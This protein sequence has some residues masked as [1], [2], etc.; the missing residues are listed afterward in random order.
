MANREHPIEQAIDSIDIDG[1]YSFKVGVG[2]VT[3]IEATT[4]SGLHADIAYV[5][6]WAGE[7]CLSEHCQHNIHGVYFSTAE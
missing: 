6:V 4:K 5:R 1:I 7:K 2:D 3:R